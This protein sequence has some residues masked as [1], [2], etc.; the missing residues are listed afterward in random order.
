MY[1]RFGSVAAG[2]LF[3]AIFTSSLVA[4]TKPATAPSSAPPPAATAKWVPP[5]KG[6]ATVEFIKAKPKRVKGEIVTSMKVKNTSKGSIALLSV[7]EVWYNTKREIATNG[8]YRHR[9]LLN[10]G[11]VIEFEI[12][13][14]D[15]PDLYTN[16]F[17]FK[18]A[19][20]SV[21]PTE[22]KKM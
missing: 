2:C 22:V 9:A 21:K 14:V 10:P 19:N 1:R 16:L 11:E 5:V 7:E 6:E 15:K 20:G 18:H 4:Q 13:S 12:K 17:L 3:T 8:I